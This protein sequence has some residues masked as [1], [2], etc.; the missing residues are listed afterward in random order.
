[1]M[2]RAGDGS[3]GRHTEAQDSKETVDALSARVPAVVLSPVVLQ[4]KRRKHP[5]LEQG[6]L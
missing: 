2:A 6:S 1:M 5:F 3:Y 4:S